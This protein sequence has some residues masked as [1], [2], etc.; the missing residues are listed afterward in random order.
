[1]NEEQLNFEIAKYPKQRFSYINIAVKSMKKITF[2]ATEAAQRKS[3][4]HSLDVWTLRNLGGSFN[5]RSSVTHLQDF[6]LCM[7]SLH[8]NAAHWH[9]PGLG[10]L[11][12]ICVQVAIYLH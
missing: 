2:F 8:W 10:P 1:M 12:V 3:S 5:Y 9:G 11:D 6:F 4:V 7:K